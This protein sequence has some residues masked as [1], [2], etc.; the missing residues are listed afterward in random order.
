MSGNSSSGNGGN[1]GSG[2]GAGQHRR[3]DP[4]LSGGTPPP[5]N[6]D[7]QVQNPGSGTGRRRK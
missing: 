3:E 6:S 2:S 4:P 5:G 1:S 7:G